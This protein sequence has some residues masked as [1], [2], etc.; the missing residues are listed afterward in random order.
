V[1]VM[2]GTPM[3]ATIENMRRC[4]AAGLHV[5]ALELNSEDTYS[6][7][8]GDYFWL[9]EGQPLTGRDGE[10]CILVREIPASYAPVDESD[11]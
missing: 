2:S 7:T 4:E 5:V 1:V 10:P 11:L 6:A 3:L 9:P 8:P